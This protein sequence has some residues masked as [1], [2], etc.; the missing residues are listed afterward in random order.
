[1]IIW[2]GRTRVRVM[3]GSWEAAVCRAAPPSLVQVLLF[4][5]IS[6]LVLLVPFKGLD[7]PSHVVVPDAVRRRG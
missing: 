6:H 2:F 1:M 4:L 7:V 5:L 3:P